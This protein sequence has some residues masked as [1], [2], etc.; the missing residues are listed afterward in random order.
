MQIKFTLL[1]YSFNFALK[2]LIMGTSKRMKVYVLLN[3]KGFIGVWSNLKN[4]VAEMKET[5]SFV[6]YSKLSKM[7]KELGILEFE[8]KE[9]VSYKIHIGKVR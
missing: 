2:T 7:P 1:S 4:L 6:S 3:E 5:T 8:D 9:G